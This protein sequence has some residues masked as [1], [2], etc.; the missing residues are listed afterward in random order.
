MCV[1]TNKIPKKIKI[2][3]V[4]ERKRER[5]MKENIKKILKIYTNKMEI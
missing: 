2:R 1:R 4:E 3:D 5:Q